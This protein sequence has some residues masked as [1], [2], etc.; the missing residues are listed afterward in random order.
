MTP[1]QRNILGPLVKK[2]SHHDKHLWWELKREIFDRGYQ[3]H[4]MREFEFTESA[5]ACLDKLSS[6]EISQLAKEWKR[7]DPQNFDESDAKLLA[8][9]T[10]IIVE[11][12][13]RRAFVA[14][15]RTVNW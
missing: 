1:L 6:V 11:E 7:D 2:V 15:K 5:K 13:V 3:P 14:A 4:Y 10:S 8:F 12:V 9:Y